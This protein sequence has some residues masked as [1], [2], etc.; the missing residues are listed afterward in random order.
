MWGSVNLALGIIGVVSAY[1]QQPGALTDTE[2]LDASR[3]ARNVFLINDAL[4]V[5]YIGAGTLSHVLGK[6]RG[7]ERATGYGSS[8][9]AQGIALLVFDGVMAALHGQTLRRV[10][11]ALSLGPSEARLTL[12]ISHG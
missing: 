8:V 12:R 6:R 1:R 9:I 10:S 4:D 2:A 7:S 5:L 3:R 11:P